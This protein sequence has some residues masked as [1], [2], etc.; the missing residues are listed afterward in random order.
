[1][2]SVEKI[3]KIWGWDGKDKCLRYGW[4]EDHLY[5]LCYPHPT[6]R[7]EWLKQ[8]DKLCQWFKDQENKK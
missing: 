3:K 4:P 2:C 6:A 7:E 1:M 5:V 8:I